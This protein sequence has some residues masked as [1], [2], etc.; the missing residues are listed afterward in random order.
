MFSSRLGSFSVPLVMAAVLVGC[1]SGHAPARPESESGRLATSGTND[2]LVE[3]GRSTVQLPVGRLPVHLAVTRSGTAFALSSLSGRAR[4]VSFADHS[5]AIRTVVRADRGWLI[6]DIRTA[7]NWVIWV[8]Q[9][10][11]QS[12]PD[13]SVSWR[14]GGWNSRTDERANIAPSLK[15][16]PLPPGVA[17]TN[18]RIVYSE[19]RG[20]NQRTADFF[21]YSFETGKLTPVATNIAGLQ[22]A[23]DGQRVLTTITEGTS[24]AGAS[25][26]DIYE[27][28]PDGPSPL[29]K[30]DHSASPQLDGNYLMWTT[31]GRAVK[32][33][34]LLH[35]KV[36]TV[37]P[38]DANA[39]TI[40]NGFVVDVVNRDGNYDAR[41]WPV[42]GQAGPTWLTAPEGQ[43]AFGGVVAQ[44]HWL[45]WISAS[46]GGDP[47]HGSTLISE[48]VGFS[49]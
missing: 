4:R 18:K 29:T 5:G 24:R 48:R 45:S 43:H 41:L 25:R 31:R 47:L 6:A 20:L 19:Y 33:Q 8:E 27:L 42:A 1:H 21:R 22:V 15:D 10:G 32:V 3:T 35:D 30:D 40:G 2:H 12:T 7:G 39:P 36:A 26:S 28:L 46:H 16:S 37:I 38:A 49:N 34:N 13:E 11:P 17:G 23:Y 9:D 14:I 44:G